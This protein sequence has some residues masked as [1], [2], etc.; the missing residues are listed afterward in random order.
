[1]DCI[2]YYFCLWKLKKITRRLSF[3]TFSGLENNKNEWGQYYKFSQPISRE[4]EEKAKT[5]EKG[6]IFLPNSSIEI[7]PDEQ[8]P[9]MINK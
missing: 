8:E 5:E 3:V 6:R 7:K 1:M 4:N 9:L 2:F